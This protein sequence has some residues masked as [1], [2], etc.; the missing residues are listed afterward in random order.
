MIGGTVR[1]EVPQASDWLNTYCNSAA[2][3]LRES[4]NATVEAVRVHR[5]WDAV[6]FS[7]N[8]PEFSLAGSWISKAR[9]DCVENDQLKSGVIQDTLF[10]GCFYG[11]SMDPARNVPLP[12]SVHEVLVLES[13]I[14]RMATYLAR[15]RKVQGVPFKAHPSSPK[16][17]IYN[18]VFAF[19]NPHV[20]GLRR[21][22]RAWRKT[23]GC[24][25]NLILWMTDGPLPHDFPLPPSCFRIVKGDSAM[26]L[27]DRVRNNWI[28]CH[29]NVGRLRDDPTSRPEQCESKLFGAHR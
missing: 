22:A 15:G 13:V 21:L 17:R 20:V 23:I 18:S 1:G 6:R 26:A 7:K 5:A 12:S 24:R 3:G 4:A 29:P 28:N 9:D 10:D 2:I 8:S 16:L 19:D 25:N 27:W 11:I 14:M